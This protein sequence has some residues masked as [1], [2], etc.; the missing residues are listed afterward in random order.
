[1]ADLLTGPVK[2][3]CSVINHS[4]AAQIDEAVRLIRGPRCFDWG[5]RLQNVDQKMKELLSDVNRSVVTC[6]H[7]RNVNVV[8]SV[9][10]RRV[11]DIVR[12]RVPVLW[13]ETL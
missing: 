3:L 9:N 4:E 13:R 7:Q 12:W 8:V 11:L 6:C 1:M 2:V 5:E 10:V